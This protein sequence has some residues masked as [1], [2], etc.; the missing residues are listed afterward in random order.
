MEEGLSPIWSREVQVYDG[1]NS[2][3][4]LK[5]P[6]RVSRYTETNERYQFA[7][8]QSHALRPGSFQQVDHLLVKCSVQLECAGLN[9]CAWHI[10]HRRLSCDGSRTLLVHVC[11]T[12]VIRK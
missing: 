3:V 11:G 7:Y 2:P 10:V 6:I 8:I 9:I 1:R 12:G 4:L 5:F